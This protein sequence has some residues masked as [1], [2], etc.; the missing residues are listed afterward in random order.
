MLRFLLGS[1]FLLAPEPAAPVP[2]T[3]TPAP[4]PAPAPEPPSNEPIQLT[5]EQLNQRLRRHHATQIR[6]LGFESPEALQQR[7]ARAK[8]LEDA[9][10]ERIRASQTREQQLEADLAAQRAARAQLEA[11]LAEQRFA[12]NVA[13]VAAELGIRNLDYAAFQ[14]RSLRPSAAGAPEPTRDQIAERF[15]ELTAQPAHQAAFGLPAPPPPELVPVPAT[16]T[17]TLPG[18]APPAPPAPPPPGKGPEAVDA[19]KMSA[20]EFRAH[21]ATIGGPS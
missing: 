8:E 9:E 15:R 10:A 5:S 7:L 4:A 13:S 21:L 14:A 12:G 6:E 18:G 1:V 3:P 17:P 11:Q 2:G 16:T 19:M 20:A